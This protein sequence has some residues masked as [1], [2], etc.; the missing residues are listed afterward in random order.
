MIELENVGKRY[1]TR[2][3]RVTAL[4]GISL[5]IGAGEK[6]CIVGKSGSGKTTLVD[7]VGTLL[8][9]TSGQ[10]RLF[11][12]PVNSRTG[13]ELARLRNRHFGFVF[14]AFHLMDR[15][16]VLDN[17]CLGARYRSADPGFRRR[18]RDLLERLGLGGF[19]GRLPTQLSGGEKQRVAIARAL[20]GQPS[21]ILADEPTGNL[22]SDTGALVIEAL[23]DACGPQTALVLVTHDM[24]FAER[25]D[26]LVRMKDGQIV[27]G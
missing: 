23:F 15:S 3:G 26:R 25:F 6:L 7:I 1:G 14:Q 21:V 18:A 8:T 19:E 24:G 4:R 17:V 13:P 10:Y 12:S 11:G 2:S 9:P 5:S 20:A 16:T 22:D 27:A